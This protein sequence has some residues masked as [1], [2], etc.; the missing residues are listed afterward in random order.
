MNGREERSLAHSLLM[1][2]FSPNQ[3]AHNDIDQF[4]VLL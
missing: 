3:D 4:I 2:S 1:L